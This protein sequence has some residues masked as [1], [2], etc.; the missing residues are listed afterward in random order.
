MNSDAWKAE[1]PSLEE[2]FA[3]FGRRLPA[4]MKKQLDELKAR[5]G[6]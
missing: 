4:R 5:L 3:Q 2:H 6:V 1:I